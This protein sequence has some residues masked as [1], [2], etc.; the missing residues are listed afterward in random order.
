MACRARQAFGRR[1]LVY[2]A[3]TGG[4][5]LITALLMLATARSDT[6]G[7][8]MGAVFG[9]GLWVLG[10]LPYVLWNTVALIRALTAGRPV[11]VPAIGAALP[12]VGLIL[13]GPVLDGMWRMLVR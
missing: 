2:L 1:N 4:C 6:A 12:A 7:Q 5:L 9:I 11:R 8:G 10:S 3:F 13:G